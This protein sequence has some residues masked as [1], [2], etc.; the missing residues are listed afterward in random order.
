MRNY[1]ESIAVDSLVAAVSLLL[2]LQSASTDRTPQFIA[3]AVA[4]DRSVAVVAAAG[5]VG[6]VSA[7]NSEL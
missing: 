6:V 2:L 7:T 3:P 4:A 1:D 5:V